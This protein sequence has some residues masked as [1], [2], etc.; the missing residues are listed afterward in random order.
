MIHNTGHSKF[1]GEKY[2]ILFYKII[3]NLLSYVTVC[4]SD[5]KIKVF[6]SSDL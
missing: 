5:S 6:W 3:E 1:I 4:F 2:G